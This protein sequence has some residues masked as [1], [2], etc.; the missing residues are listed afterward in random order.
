M[1]TGIEYAF[2]VSGGDIGKRLDVYLAARLPDISRSQLQRVIDSGT[3]QVNGENA[4]ASRKME[5]GDLVLV[6]LLP[7]RPSHVQP[8]PIDLNIVYEDRDVIVINKDKGMVVHPAPGAEDGTLVNA[9]LAHSNELSGIGGIARPGIVHRLDK[10]TTGLMM[11]AKNDVAHNG[12][13]KQIQ[14]HSAK[15]KYLAIVW[16]RPPFDE[17]IIDVPIMRHPIDRKKMTVCESSRQGDAR[18]AITEVRVKER[19]PLFSLF[20]CT[21]QT[22]RT[23][24]IRVHC[25]YAG[26]PVVG[27]PTY[28]GL[29]KVTPD[30]LRGMYPSRINERINLMQGQCL[31]AYSLTFEHPTTGQ[32]M[33]FF[34]PLPEEMTEFLDLLRSIPA[35]AIR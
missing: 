34:A 9:L 24:Q 17:A 16:G 32:S 28:G 14:S 30:Q 6:T 8:Q 13:Q 22:G 2:I 23:H 12:L 11:V 26:Y 27:D 18:D 4:K 7:P 33:E 35:E 25:T 1:A 3:V 5:A 20:E 19:F 10:D 31:H 21:L 29:K 15:R